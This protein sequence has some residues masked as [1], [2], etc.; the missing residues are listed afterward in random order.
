[1]RWVR[2]ALLLASVAGIRVAAAQN[3]PAAAQPSA[4]E[5]MAKVAVNQDLAVAERAHYVYVQHAKTVSRRGGTMLCQEITDYRMTPAADGTHQDLLKVD[6]QM[7]LKHRTVNYTTLLPQDEDHKNA[8]KRANE[9]D[10]SAKPDAAVS[11]DAEPAHAGKGTGSAGDS[12]SDDSDD[13][14]IKI[15]DDESLDR[16]LV[17]NIRHGLMNDKSRD[18]IDAHLFPLTSKDQALTTFS[19]PAGNG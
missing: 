6:G 15:G 2:A 8:G 4:Q 10:K 14:V 13:I 11:K 16:E 1:M 7:R 3:A 18:G 19:L 12:N 9:A 17:E 5:I